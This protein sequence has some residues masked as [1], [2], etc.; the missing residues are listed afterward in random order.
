MPDKNHYSVLNLSP[1]GIN[2]ETGVAYTTREILQAYRKLAR[3]LHP[4][5]NLD[6]PN[7]KNNF[8]AL[9][10]S[11]KI[12]SDPNKRSDFD[13]VLAK[14][15]DAFSSNHLFVLLSENSL[16]PF[17]SERE[18]HAIV[19]YTTKGTDLTWLIINS[20]YEIEN[21][22]KIAENNKVL[23]YAILNSSSIWNL[24][25]TSKQIKFMLD[26]YATHFSDDFKG[27]KKFS[28][29]NFLC[30][31][32]YSDLQT[33]STFAA[34]CVSNVASAKIFLHA[35]DINAFI[36]VSSFMK[37][38]LLQLSQHFYFVVPYLLNQNVRSLKLSELKFILEKNPSKRKNILELLAKDVNLQKRYDASER[39]IK[40]IAEQNPN[41]SEYEDDI[42]LLGV[43]VIEI[44]IDSLKTDDFTLNFIANTVRL[45][46]DQYPISSF[47][48]DDLLIIFK[49]YLVIFILLKETNK[50][51][52]TLAKNTPALFEKMTLSVLNNCINNI[53]I[54]SL[55]AA[56]ATF[57]ANFI[58][59]HTIKDQSNIASE[60]KKSHEDYPDFLRELLKQGMEAWNGLN[61]NP[62]LLSYMLDKP[63]YF[64]DAALRIRLAH[65]YQNKN[66]TISNDV[67]E[68]LPDDFQV[69]YNAVKELRSYVTEDLKIHWLNF[70]SKNDN[71]SLL[72]YE[73]FVELYGKTEFFDDILYLQHA[74]YRVS[75]KILNEAYKYF[76]NSRLPNLSQ[77]KCVVLM[78]LECI[79]PSAT[80]EE[81]I[82]LIN[83]IKPEDVLLSL[84]R[85]DSFEQK[86]LAMR[87]LLLHEEWA[88]RF[89]TGNVLYDFEKFINSEALVTVIKKILPQEIEQS[90]CHELMNDISTR[91]NVFF[92]HIQSYRCRD[93]KKITIKYPNS[94][95]AKINT[96]KK[97]ELY[98][99]R[100][101]AYYRLTLLLD[102]VAATEAQSIPSNQTLLDVLALISSSGIDHATLT[103]VLEKLKNHSIFYDA[104][105]ASIFNDPQLKSPI[106][107]KLEPNFCRPDIGLNNLKLTLN[108]ISLAILYV[109]EYKQFASGDVLEKFKQKYGNE[110]LPVI[111]L[112]SLE[113]KTR[114]AKKVNF[115]LQQLSQRYAQFEN[116]EIDIEAEIK[117]THDSFRDFV[118]TTNTLSLSDETV[119]TDIYDKL[120]QTHNVYQDALTTILIDAYPK[121]DPTNFLSWVINC[122]FSGVDFAIIKLNILFNNGEISQL[123][124][125]LLKILEK[126]N[127]NFSKL[128]T[129]LTIE[130]KTKLALHSFKKETPDLLVS[131]HIA[132]HM[133]K[134]I[135]HRYDFDSIA[136]D[137]RNNFIYFFL[138]QSSHPFQ[139]PRD[140]KQVNKN[141]ICRLILNKIIT[142]SQLSTMNQTIVKL[143]FPVVK[144]YLHDML[145]CERRFNLTLL[146]RLDI[147]Q[148]D[149]FPL[150]SA[151]ILVESDLKKYN[152]LSLE[153]SL[154]HHFTTSTNWN[155]NFDLA[156][157]RQ[158]KTFLDSDHFRVILNKVLY[159]IQN[160]IETL[161]TQADVDQILLVK[162][163]IIDLIKDHFRDIHRINHGE[164]WLQLT[165]ITPDPE[166]FTR[167]L[168]IALRKKLIEL[169]AKIK[170]PQIYN[171]ILLKMT[172]PFVAEG[173]NLFR[174]RNARTLFTI[175]DGIT[176]TK[177]F[178][179]VR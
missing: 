90:D 121:E 8:S 112:Y 15:P 32:I 122:A 79:L 160:L 71:P 14:N 24:V 177:K 58:L 139:W 151:G 166:K 100:V 19:P 163:E 65:L 133:K 35:N 16:L 72:T 43:D 1:S 144:N 114:Q 134:P 149:F 64:N 141:I 78:L 94:I 118:N 56:S 11:Y 91:I 119:P 126:D 98:H 170:F 125:E 97:F 53:N 29:I 83:V 175:A 148:L 115:I 96:V 76:L 93:G 7:A 17:M 57:M 117:K 18:P 86:C 95:I 59:T 50:I 103:M 154:L 77:Y 136:E 55:D 31:K 68:T 69:C 5:Y 173:Y 171:E 81:I 44:V 38:S 164:N 25:E 158:M 123:S 124:D 21:L 157:L 63:I 67:F 26:T 155:N 128:N 46:L 41:L 116:R 22:L 169:A 54:N 140:Q 172:K 178:L 2:D 12:L 30:K 105:I 162:K 167:T 36:P 89:I 159:P 66:I 120:T 73:K 130:N 33:E 152:A 47:S 87:K 10:D 127:N 137:I 106:L 74:D 113:Q 85:I 40:F 49:A 61:N 111:Q 108:Y 39:I 135:E 4:D 179:N 168:H 27:F 37:E 143:N 109:H 34:V 82:R 145:D 150:L 174:P 20:D 92:Q 156:R 51:G 129:I 110:I 165:D 28:N 107:N 88:K 52:F 62:C 60:E 142:F 42:R 80:D 6:D 176:Q 84:L 70:M 3:K 161:P 75:L 101:R 131:L 102:Q 99:P 146:E 45:T 104:I 13:R 48:S 23:T 132:E 153:F 9:D 138:K 147:D